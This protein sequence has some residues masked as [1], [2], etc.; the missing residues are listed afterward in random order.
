MENKRY[1]AAAI[2]GIIGFMLMLGAVGSMEFGE[3]SEREALIRAGIGM[4]FLLAAVP[5]SGDYKK[6]NRP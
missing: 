5:V 3:I 4:A 1:I 6:E 2:L